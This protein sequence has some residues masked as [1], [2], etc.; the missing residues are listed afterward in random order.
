VKLLSKIII[1]LLCINFNYISGLKLDRVIL[2][3]DNN[4]KYI[5]FWPIVA[6]AWKSSIGVKPT[7]ALISDSN[8]EID[9]T[10]GDII[11]I[12]PIP[13]IP[14]WFQAQN[15][16]LILPI[17]FPDEVC[18]TSDMDMLPLSKDF[19]V[20]KINKFKADNFVVYRNGSYDV[21]TPK[22]PICYLAAKGKIFSEILD[23]NN[24][25]DYESR[26]KE[27]FEYGFGW[28]TDE[29]VFY[30]YLTKWSKYKS[31]CKKLGYGKIIGDTID[32]AKWVYNIGWLK[33]G[34]Y[35]QA[36]LLR[37]YKRYKTQIDKLL[38][39]LQN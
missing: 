18:I 15:I 5:D 24:F 39:D 29:L 16:R 23:L 28:E 9:E 13:G 7:L 27:W 11:R 3:V 22:F 32:R 14:T 38:L 6:K 30:Q 17:L 35:Y 8:I 12:K 10:L 25:A 4:P 37:P 1:L 26:I 21:K 20:N 19:F 34:Y 33:K 31:K 2:A 36:H